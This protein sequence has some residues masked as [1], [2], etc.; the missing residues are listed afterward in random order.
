[1]STPERALAVERARGGAY[2]RPGARVGALIGAPPIQ[3]DAVAPRA[4]D[5]GVRGRGGTASLAR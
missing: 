3:K 5:I 1:M 2:A 4:R